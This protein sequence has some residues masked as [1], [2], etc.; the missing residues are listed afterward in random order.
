MSP[1]PGAFEQLFCP[2]GGAFASLFKKVLIPGG[3]P[4]GGG[5][6][7]LLEL[8]DALPSRSSSFPVQFCCP[9]PKYKVLLQNR[10]SLINFCILTLLVTSTQVYET[11]VQCH[12]KQ[13]FSGL[14]SPHNLRTC[15][16]CICRVTLASD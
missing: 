2:G 15:E 7:A 13:S 4:G 3:R 10:I 11:S 6:W 9:R 8:T 12:L 16:I 1:Y 14:H 5:R